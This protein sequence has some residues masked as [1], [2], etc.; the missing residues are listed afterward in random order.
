MDFSIIM[1]VALF[2][3]TLGLLA[4]IPLMFHWYLKGLEEGK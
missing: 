3:F 4:A 2:S 1:I